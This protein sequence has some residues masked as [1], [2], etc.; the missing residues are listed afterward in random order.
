MNKNQTGYKNGEI[1]DE[2]GVSQYMQEGKQAKPQQ[3]AKSP[4][5]S[6]QQP[7]AKPQQQSPQQAKSPQQVKPQQQSQQQPQAKP[8]QQ[9]T[10]NELMEM[11][12]EAILTGAVIVIVGG[13]LLTLLWWLNAFFT[14]QGLSTIMNWMDEVTGAGF[15]AST[16]TNAGKFVY[17]I[18]ASFTIAQFLVLKK[19]MK[20]SMPN[21][22]VLIVTSFVTF[23][24]ALSTWYGLSVTE[25]PLAFLKIFNNNWP[26][27]L[28]ATLFL[29]IAGEILLARLEID[30]QR[31][32]K[33]FWGLVQSLWKTRKNKK[34]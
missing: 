7:Q 17:V 6:P 20:S 25:M 26:G 30:F 33:K 24:D 14:V 1:T 11:L 8:Q 21:V 4:Q 12:T 23:L 5:Q 9:A 3:Q 22:V 29:A 32:K 10:I 27:Q 19:F 31:W 15:F 2:E 34:K 13:M 16:W 18:P 28:I